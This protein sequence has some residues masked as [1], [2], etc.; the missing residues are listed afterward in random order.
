MRVST[1]AVI[2][3]T[4]ADELM[5]VSDVFDHQM[6]P[7]SFELIALAAASGAERAVADV[8]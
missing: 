4:Q 1:A 3:E 2:G 5:I 7:R 6:R 8:Q